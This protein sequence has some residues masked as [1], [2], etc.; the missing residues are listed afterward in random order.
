ML[1]EFGMGLIAVANIHFKSTEKSDV[2]VL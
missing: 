1:I 2:R